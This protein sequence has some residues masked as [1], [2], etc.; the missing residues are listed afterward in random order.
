M[1]GT[2]KELYNADMARYSGSPSLYLR[3]FHYLYR[4]AC[5]TYFAPLKLIYKVL[6]RF[7]ASR[8]GLEIPVNQ[9]IGGGYI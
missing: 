8:K 6:F 9:L 2:F 1:A 5:M 7:W 4:R 3:V